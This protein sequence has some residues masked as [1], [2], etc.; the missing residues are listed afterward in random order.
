MNKYVRFPDFKIK[1]V[2]LSY[3]DGIRQ[4]KRLIDI[5]KKNG[6]RGSFNINGGRFSDSFNGETAGV[7]TRE[8]ALDLYIPSGMEVALHGYRH[9][10]LADVP[11]PLATDEMVADRRAHEALFDRIIRGMAYAN[12][13]YN[14]EVISMLRSLGVT[15][16]RTVKSTERFDLPLDWLEWHPTCHHNNPRLMDLA[17][18]FVEISER[19]YFWARKLSVFYLWGHSY[20]LDNND[21]W[22]VIEEFAEFIGGREDIWY[23]TNGEICDYMRAAESLVYSIDGKI[24]ENPTAIDIYLN[25]GDRRVIVPATGS[26]RV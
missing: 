9:L 10:S 5:M 16:A 12:G 24:I 20:E 23:A 8:E 19:G 25:L 15:Y 7:M 4:D 13:S 2:T 14:G 11:M 26:V 6:L 22:Q 17:R 3:D 18:E 21:N 1:A